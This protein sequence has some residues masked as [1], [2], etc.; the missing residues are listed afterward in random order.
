MRRA[1]TWGL[2]ALTAVLLFT[3]FFP[4]LTKVLFH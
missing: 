1:P 3:S 2:I 4:G